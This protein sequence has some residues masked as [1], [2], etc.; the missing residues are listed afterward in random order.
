MARGVTAAGDTL[1]DEVEQ[2][3]SPSPSPGKRAV[4]K[5]LPALPARIEA[6]RIYL[7]PYE[8][9]DGP[10]YYAMSQRNRS[11]L[12]RYEADNVVMSIESEQDAGAV[13]QDL[14]AAWEA[15]TC[16]FLGAFDRETDGFVAQVYVG[17]VDWDVPE[18]EI[19]FFVDRDREGQ[20][21]VTEAVRAAMGF[22]F[23]HLGAHRVRMECDDTNM[24]SRRVAERCGLVQ[25]GHVRENKR[26]AD[27]TLSGTLHFGL[28]K[29]EYEAMEKT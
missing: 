20:G 19:G 25:E 15:R 6:G 5:M 21:Y 8:A 16:F 14:G 28:L 29:S 27:G 4:P 11:H 13:V 23:A 17:P 3:S 24:R 22:V 10:W 7:R 1:T 26:N 12:A 18:F 2:T 9:G